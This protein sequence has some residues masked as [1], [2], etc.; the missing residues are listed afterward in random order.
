MINPNWARS[1]IPSSEATQKSGKKSND[2]KMKFGGHLGPC[3]NLTHTSQLGLFCFDN[4]LIK[5]QIRV[6]R[7]NEFLPKNLLKILN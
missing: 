7:V 2:A 3:V 4:D 5:L 6:V 1:K